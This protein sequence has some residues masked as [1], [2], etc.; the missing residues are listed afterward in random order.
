MAID[1][2]ISRPL[3]LVILVLYMVLIGSEVQ[4]QIK[5]QQALQRRSAKGGSLRQLLR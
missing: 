3:A 1:K 4:R 2:H 5:R